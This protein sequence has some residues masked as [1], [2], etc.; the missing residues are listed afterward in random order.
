M[1]ALLLALFLAPLGAHAD[2]SRIGCEEILPEGTSDSGY[3]LQID[4][5]RQHAQVDVGSIAGPHKV[6]DL[7]CKP[8]METMEAPVGTHPFLG[9]EGQ[10]RIKAKVSVEVFAKGRVLEMHATMTFTSKKG[11]KHVVKMDCQDEK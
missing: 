2:G 10:D 11:E 6:A 5:D 9:C 8:L 7:D 3:A 1:K 4:V